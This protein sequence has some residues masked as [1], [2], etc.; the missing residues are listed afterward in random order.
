MSTELKSDREV[1]GQAVGLRE[2]TET[3]EDAG[4]LVGDEDVAAAVLR[5]RDARAGARLRIVSGP[6]EGRS[7]F[8]LGREDEVRRDRERPALPI[9]DERRLERRLEADRIAKRRWDLV[10]RRIPCMRVEQRL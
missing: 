3:I 2:C 9:K 4:I 8:A 7:I 1:R 10:V 6:D 5:I